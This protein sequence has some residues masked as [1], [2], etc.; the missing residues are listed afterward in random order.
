M[1]EDRVLSAAEDE[2]FDALRE[3]RREE[4]ALSEVPGFTIFSN[5]TLKAIAMRQPGTLAELEDVHGVGPA[6]IEAYG[7]T[8]LRLLDRFRP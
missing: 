7:D 8:V 6:K 5:R 4:A 3:W 1:A 2:I